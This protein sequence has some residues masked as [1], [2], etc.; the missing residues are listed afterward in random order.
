MVDKASGRDLYHL[1]AAEVPSTHNV[2]D[3]IASVH[4]PVIR[5]IVR[6]KAGKPVEFDA[7]LDVS[8]VNRWTRLACYSFEVYNEA[9]IYRQSLNASENGRD[10]IQRRSLRTRSTKNVN[11]SATARRM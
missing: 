2:S 10:T 11:A 9:A 1:F 8:V 6:R 5:P 4:K 3:R 7:K